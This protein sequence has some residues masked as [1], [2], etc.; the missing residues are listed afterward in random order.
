[1][2]G[3]ANEEFALFRW[4]SWVGSLIQALAGRLRIAGIMVVNRSGFAVRAAASGLV[5]ALVDEGRE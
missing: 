2:T 5:A 1:M 4:T 3:G